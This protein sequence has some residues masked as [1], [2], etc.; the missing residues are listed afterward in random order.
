ML[1][2]PE[3]IFFQFGHNAEH[4]T[5]AIGTQPVFKGPYLDVT[6]KMGKGIMSTGFYGNRRRPG[7]MATVLLSGTMVLQCSL[8]SDLAYA[9]ADP[10]IRYAR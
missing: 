3:P 4:S 7:I 8:L 6:R 2:F 5:A 1:E 10:R 9:V